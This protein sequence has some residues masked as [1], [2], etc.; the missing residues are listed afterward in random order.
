MV[1]RLCEEIWII[2]V[3]DL[4]KGTKRE[5]GEIFYDPIIVTG[6]YKENDDGFIICKEKLNTVI[7]NIH[8][9]YY[10]VKEM[11]MK[12]EDLLNILLNSLLSDLKYGFYPNFH[13]YPVNKRY[14]IN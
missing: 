2:L 6:A 4:V 14:L 12:P 10:A 9:I 8:T 13:Q 1:R 5:A 3:C 7:I 11:R